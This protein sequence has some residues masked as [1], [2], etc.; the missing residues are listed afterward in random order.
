MWASAESGGRGATSQTGTYRATST[1]LGDRLITVGSYSWA[2]LH[3]TLQERG[4]RN[5]RPRAVPLPDM[6]GLVLSNPE[7]VREV[8]AGTEEACRGELLSWH[9]VFGE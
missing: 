3:A 9:D 4:T 2:G 5:W 1:C 7:L 8:A 6:T